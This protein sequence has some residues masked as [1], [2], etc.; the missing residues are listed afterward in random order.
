MAAFL[1]AVSQKKIHL[2]IIPRQFVQKVRN[3]ISICEDS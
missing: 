1:Y 3:L 2:Y